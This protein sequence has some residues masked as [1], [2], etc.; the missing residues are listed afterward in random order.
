MFRYYIEIDGGQLCSCSTYEE[1]S[2]VY[3]SLKRELM[4]GQFIALVGRDLEQ[5]ASV[6]VY[7]RHDWRNRR[8]SGPL[9]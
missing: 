7:Y 1:A 8:P 9:I 4:P 2:R 3:A 5:L 6:P